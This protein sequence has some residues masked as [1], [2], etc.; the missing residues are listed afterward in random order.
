MIPTSKINVGSKNKL[1]D[2]KKKHFHIV[3]IKKLIFDTTTRVS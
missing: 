3:A 1:I 2:I